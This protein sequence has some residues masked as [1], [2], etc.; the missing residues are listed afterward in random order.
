MSVQASKRLIHRTAD[1][2]SDWTDSAL[3]QANF[4]EIG[5]LMGTADAMEGPRAFAEKREPQWRGE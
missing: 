1:F 3:W 5:S 4:E 2:G